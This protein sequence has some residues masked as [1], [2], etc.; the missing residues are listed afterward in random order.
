MMLKHTDAFARRLVVG[1][2]LV[3]RMV[4]YRIVV[5]KMVVD[6]IAL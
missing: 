1:I 5:E 3:G 6:K 2:A 4:G